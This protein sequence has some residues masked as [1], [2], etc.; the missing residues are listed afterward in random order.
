M[1]AEPFALLFVG[2]QALAAGFAVGE[3]GAASFGVAGA[4]TARADLPEVGFYN[5]AAWAFTQGMRASVGATA[6]QPNIVH[7]D[8][9]SGRETQALT[10]TETPPYL[11]G[12]Y[13]FE[14]VALGFAFGVPFGSGVSWPTDSSWGGRFEITDIALRTFE[15]AP[16]LAVRITDQVALAAG[17]RWVMGDVYM[18]RQ[19]PLGSVE[20][21]VEL[22]GQT[23]TLAGQAALLVRPTEELSLGLTYRSRVQLDFTGDAN[24]EDIPV[25]FSPQAHDGGVRTAVTLPDRVALG[26]ALTLAGVTASVDLEYYHWSTFQELAIDFTDETMSD[27]E[28][29]E[30][31]WVNTLAVRAG[32]EVAEL[33]EG[34]S[35][36]GGLCYDPTPAPTHTLSPSLPDGN[37]LM[38]TV[39]GT[40]M[41][42]GGVAAHAAYGR[43]FFLGAKAEGEA[44]PGE[45]HASANLV[46]L[47]LSYTP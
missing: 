23:R 20:G 5:P 44:F 13:G 35:V 21:N 36:R 2:S 14:R 1:R 37:R 10:G 40:Y 32:V 25:E 3:Q 33:A 9:G 46:S 31:A 22:G 12:S 24:F 7:V 19:V 34:L 47:G 45:Y 28:P 27:P 17:P 6:I 29:E 26:G 39:G 15:L 42:G 38:T 11:Y 4:A 41:V 16:T 30:R 8:P 43:V 18:K